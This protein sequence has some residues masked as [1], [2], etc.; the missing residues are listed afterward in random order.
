M[1]WLFLSFLFF[2]NFTQV[3]AIDEFTV[4]EQIDYQV[5]NENLASVVHEIKI[6]NNFSQFYPKEY[7]L[8]LNGI[9]PLE[10]QA[11][12]SQ[13]SILKSQEVQKDGLKIF[14]SLPNAKVGKDQTTSFF[15][16][17]Q[18]NNFATTKGKTKE[19]YLPQYQNSLNG[20]VTVNLK[21]P[22]SFG[23][24]SF[25]SIDAKTVSDPPFY[26]L[27]YPPKIKKFY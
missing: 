15:I 10:L 2:S 3:S 21:I 22:Q 7:Q 6:T 23:R 8:S 24:L 14:L 27:N 5:S 20:N 25:S 18:L 11:T 4:T 9:N 1:F 12:D 13:G 17:Y 26:L 16:R 19:I